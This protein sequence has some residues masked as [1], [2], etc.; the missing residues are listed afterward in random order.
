MSNK[1]FLFH[2]TRS[3]IIYKGNVFRIGFATHTAKLGFSD[4]CIQ[5]MGRWNSGSIYSE[6][7]LPRQFKNK[8]NFSTLKKT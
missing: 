1:H 7:H 5:R 2:W 6:I 8:I 3:S 4:K